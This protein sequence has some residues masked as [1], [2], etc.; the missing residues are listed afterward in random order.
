MKHFYDLFN[1][2][3]NT[4]KQ[5]KRLIKVAQKENHKN[6]LKYQIQEYR[7]KQS[8]I[9]QK[10]YIFQECKNGSILGNLLK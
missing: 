1:E 5:E 10:W 9:I 4:G 2:K 6:L 3:H 7:N 8:R